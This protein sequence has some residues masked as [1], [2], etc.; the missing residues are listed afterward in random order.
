M[1]LRFFLLQ[2]QFWPKIALFYVFF[3]HHDA[4]S[5]KENVGEKLHF[6]RIFIPAPY[7]PEAFFNAISLFKR[8]FLRKLHFLH[9]LHLFCIYC[10]Y[11]IFLKGSRCIFHPL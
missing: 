9:F 11:C 6:Y 10:I 8:E 5:V 3:L 2:F 1:L 4:T 7:D